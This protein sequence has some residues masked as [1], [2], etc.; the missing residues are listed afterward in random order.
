[1]GFSL[2]L[3]AYVEE[4][5]ADIITKAILGGVTLGQGVDIRTGIK[6]TEKIPNL[7]VSVPFQAGTS[8]SFTTSGTTTIDQVTIATSPIAIAQEWCLKDLEAY[9]TQKYL[10]AGANEQSTSL[11]AQIMDRMSARVASQVESMI[12]QGKTTYGNS[13][14]LKQ[15]NGWLATIDTAGTAVAATP[16]T[17]N[18]T[19]VL[20]IFDNVYASIPAAA[21]SNETVVAFVGYDTFRLLAAKITATYGIYGSNY[22]TDGVWA[23]WTLM[24]PGTN[25]KV[26]AVPGLNNDNAVDTGVLPTAVKNRIVATYASNLVFGTDLISDI[27][28][29]E[30]W[31]SKDDR[32]LKVYGEFRA[33]V[34]V[35]YMDHVVQYIN[36]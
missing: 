33:G 15:I 8:C 35:K 13:T 18:A 2:S 17:L 22:N 21:I 30:A 34:A 31:Y 32:K 3:T 23:K 27:G 16:S 14:V 36:S 26:I 5:K 10:P 20:T 25:M 29:L 1:M 12:W 24:Y 9:F 6:S 19:N 28:N 11:E 4:N 7:D